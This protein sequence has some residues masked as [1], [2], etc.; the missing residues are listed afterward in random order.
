M[1]VRASGMKVVYYTSGTTGSGRIVRGISVANGFRRKAAHVD[2]TIVSSS[3]FA[4]LADLFDIPHNEITAETEDKLT[5]DSYAKSELFRLLNRLE[6]D[7]LLIDLLW[8]PVYH[9]VENLTCRTV[10]L[11]EQL[12]DRFFTIPLPG[13]A[14]SYKP[15]KF[16]LV[17]SIEPFKGVR[18]SY[19]VFFQCFYGLVDGFFSTMGSSMTKNGLSSC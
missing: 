14:I 11:W 5:R 9:F 13:G 1:S 10:F 18:T 16:D 19:R 15:E 17:L 8:F 6:P 12:D 3:P 7:V 4:Y 2:F